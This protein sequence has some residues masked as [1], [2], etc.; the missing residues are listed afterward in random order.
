[1]CLDR[2]MCI[3]D[4]RTKVSALC[5]CIVLPISDLKVYHLP[6]TKSNQS[7]INMPKEPRSGYQR[8]IR[9]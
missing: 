4:K 1:M 2:N 5:L 3:R 6:G 9:E 7:Q 8:I